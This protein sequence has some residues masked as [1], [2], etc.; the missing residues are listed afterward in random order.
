MAKNTICLWY[1]KDAEAAARFYA[2]TFAS[3]NFN[4]RPGL[5]FLGKLITQFGS[6]TRGK[7][8]H[9]VREV[10]IVVRLL[11]VSQPAKGFDDRILRLGLTGIDHVVYFRYAAKMRMVQR[12]YGS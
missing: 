6:T 12:A 10:R 2:E 11:V 4:I 7:R 8:N 5:V 1:D 3:G 9:L